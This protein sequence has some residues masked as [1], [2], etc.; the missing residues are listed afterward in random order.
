MVSMKQP[1]KSSPHPCQVDAGLSVGSMG[2]V[3]SSCS[4]VTALLLSCVFRTSAPIVFLLYGQSLLWPFGAG[5]KTAQVLEISNL[6][7]LRKLWGIFHSKKPTAPRMAFFLAYAQLLADSMTG[8]HYNFQK[9]ME[10][11]G[12]AADTDFISKKNRPPK[13]PGARKSCLK[14]KLLF[15]FL[16]GGGITPPFPFQL[17]EISMFLSFSY[18]LPLR[19]HMVW[20][21]YQTRIDPTGE[22]TDMWPGERKQQLTLTLCYFS[23]TQVIVMGEK[24]Q[25]LLMITQDQGSKTS[26]PGWRHGRVPHCPYWSIAAAV[27]RWN[28]YQTYMG[29]NDLLADTKML[30]V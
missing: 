27:F 24:S 20:S 3:H 5:P 19:A 14:K 7:L 26:I 23:A 15:C 4:Q 17:V 12:N 6:A 18:F 13:K 28:M 29:G 8:E 21:T 11:T 16:G 22:N 25:R 9:E 30:G 2:T 1:I 10:S